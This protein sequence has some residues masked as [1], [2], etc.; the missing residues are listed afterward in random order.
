MKRELEDNGYV[1]L[2]K[3]YSR[4]NCDLFLKRIKQYSNKDFAPIMNPDREEFLISQSLNK[5]QNFDRLRNATF[6]NGFTLY[7]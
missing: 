2:K 4:K 6:Q 7:I 5:I 1:I 3:F